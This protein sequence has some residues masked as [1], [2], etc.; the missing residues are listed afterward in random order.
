MASGSHSSSPKNLVWIR[1]MKSKLVQLC[2]HSPGW[3]FRLR[4]IH[5]LDHNRLIQDYEVDPTVMGPAG[6]IVVGIHRRRVR[7]AGDMESGPG[8]IVVIA[9]KIQHSYA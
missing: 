6:R 9:E 3:W 2:G 8:K 7:I 4:G 5:I 1:G